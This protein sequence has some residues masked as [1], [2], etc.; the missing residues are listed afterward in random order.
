MTK[1]EL[2][3]SLSLVTSKIEVEKSPRPT[4]KKADKQLRK[5]LDPLQ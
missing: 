3:F 4:K 1:S 5:A 2:R